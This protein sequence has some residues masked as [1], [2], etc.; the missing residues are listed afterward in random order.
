MEGKRRKIIKTSRKRKKRIV[1][2]SR[3]KDSKR[4]FETTKYK[5]AKKPDS[6]FL[7]GEQGGDST[8]LSR[9]MK[10]EETATGT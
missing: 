9:A 5:G 3:E 1:G 8:M 7:R 4:D 2:W 6:I 10:M